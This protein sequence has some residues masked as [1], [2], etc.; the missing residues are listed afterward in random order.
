MLYNG[1][2]HDIFVEIHL[3]SVSCENEVLSIIGV[4][5]GD[6]AKCYMTQVGDVLRKLVIKIPV[7]CTNS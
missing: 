1:G 7:S 4:R 5:V 6:I 2:P 3:V